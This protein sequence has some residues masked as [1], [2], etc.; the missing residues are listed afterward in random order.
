M[1]D[2]LSRSWNI[3]RQR[4][5]F[6]PFRPTV[7]DLS[8]RAFSTPRLFSWPSRALVRPPRRHGQPPPPTLHMWGCRGLEGGD[9]SEPSNRNSPGSDTCALSTA[10]GVAMVAA[11]A[12]GGRRRGLSLDGCG[13]LDAIRGGGVSSMRLNKA[14]G[15]RCGQVRLVLSEQLYCGLHVFRGR[16]RL[17]PPL[18]PIPVSCAVFG[19]TR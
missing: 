9:S 12:A 14:P 10:S 1:K 8:V 17:E 6:A 13:A 11:Q 19:Y 7:S 15:L 5:V 16:K 18:V 3:W 4:F 2:F